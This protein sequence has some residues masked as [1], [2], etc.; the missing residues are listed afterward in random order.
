MGVIT[1]R[2]GY[3]CIN[4]SIDAKTNKRCLLKNATEDRLRELISENLNGL[5]KVLKYNIDKGI[6]LYRITSD[7]IPF[8]SHP[9][10]EIEWWNDFKDDLIEIKKLIRKGNMRVSMHPGQYTVLNSPKKL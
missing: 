7:I 4:L 1:I 5:K 3:A 2:I 10:N 8:G 9:I 6:S